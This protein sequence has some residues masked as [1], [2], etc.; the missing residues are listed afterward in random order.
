MGE[1]K[2]G[3][4]LKKQTCT[5]LCKHQKLYPDD[6]MFGMNGSGLYISIDTVLVKN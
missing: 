2:L 1:V 3:K 5:Y 6:R 4:S